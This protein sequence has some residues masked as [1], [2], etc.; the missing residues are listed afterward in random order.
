M[1]RC[2]WRRPGCRAHGRRRPHRRLR[3][4]RARAQPKWGEALRIARPCPV[5]CKRAVRQYGARSCGKLLKSHRRGAIT[6]RRERVRQKERPGNLSVIRAAV[7]RLHQAPGVK[8]MRLGDALPRK[9]EVLKLR[10]TAGRV[11]GSIPRMPHA[12]HRPTG[13]RHRAAAE[14]GACA[15]DVCGFHDEALR[16]PVEKFAPGSDGS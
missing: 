6:A 8:G 9:G 10:K 1:V 7:G 14:A 11:H 12:A 16:S 4:R 15:D 3:R 2:T 13:V 5:R